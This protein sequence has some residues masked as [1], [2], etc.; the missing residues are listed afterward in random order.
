VLDV[1]NVV[2]C[3][4]FQPGFSWIDL[5]VFDESGRPRQD[6]G[7]ADNEPGLYFLGLHFLYSMS[8]SMIHGVSRDAERVAQIIA[9]RVRSEQR[10]AL[11]ATTSASA[12]ISARAG[13]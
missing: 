5:P 6:R 12:R 1:A 3:T 10:A 13:S 7:A 9:K 2:W 4:G 11:L 8:S